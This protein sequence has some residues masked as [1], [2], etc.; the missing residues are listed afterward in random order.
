MRDAAIAVEDD[1]DEAL[2]AVVVSESSSHRSVVD[3]IV[4]VNAKD[5]G[6]APVV[7]LQEMEEFEVVNVDAA[8][9]GCSS[10]TN[11]VIVR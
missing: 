8:A 10:S 2:D 1:D 9:S 5:D 4:D 7:L 6:S 3:L 11:T